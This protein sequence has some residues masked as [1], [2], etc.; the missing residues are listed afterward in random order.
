MSKNIENC[1]K[2]KGETVVALE[3]IVI[4]SVFSN[5]PLGNKNIK[6]LTGLLTGSTF[7]NTLIRY[8]CKM[9]LLKAL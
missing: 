5:T 8:V 4:A 7:E 9:E 2:S 6:T 1:T 3:Q